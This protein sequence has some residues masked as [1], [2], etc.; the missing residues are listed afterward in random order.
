MATIRDVAERSRCVFRYCF[1]LF[2]WIY[3][4]KTNMDKIAAAIK[5][6]G[7]KQNYLAKGLK[8]KKSHAIGVVVNALTDILLHP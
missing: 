5:K 8:T 1:A 4:K 2:E 3:S 6:L 7:F